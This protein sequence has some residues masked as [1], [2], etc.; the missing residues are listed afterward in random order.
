[1]ESSNFVRRSDGRHAR[2]SNAHRGNYPGCM[3][4]LHV[5]EPR[6]QRDASPILPIDHH[7]AASDALGQRGE[8]CT[9]VHRGF[10]KVR[11]RRARRKSE[12]HHERE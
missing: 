8:P 7:A 4:R 9:P 1:M 3:Y 5:F 2:R 11:K 10:R 6:E 12:L